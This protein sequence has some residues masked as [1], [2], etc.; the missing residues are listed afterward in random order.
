MRLEPLQRASFV[1]FCAFFVGILCFFCA[2]FVGH[3]IGFQPC[4][5]R[6]TAFWV[7]GDLKKVGDVCKKVF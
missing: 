1:E 7:L 4:T 6:V 2:F 5:V 3:K